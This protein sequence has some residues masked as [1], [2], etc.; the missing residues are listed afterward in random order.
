MRSIF[1]KLLL[2]MA[3]LCALPARAAL[4]V[5][6]CEP[7][8]GA[9]VHAL[10]GDLAKVYEATT[11]M[12]D[13]HHIQARP[14][15]IAAARRADLLVC[16]GAELEIGWLPVLTRDSGNAAIQ[17]GTPGYF[18][19]TR[20][21]TLIEVPA[22][23]DRSEGDVH[24]QGNPHIQTDPRNIAKVATA[25]AERLAAVDPPNAAEYRKRYADFAT[26]WQ[27]AIERWTREAAPLKGVRVVEHH[28]AFSYLFRWLGIEVTAYLEAKPG[29]EP[30]AGHLAE[31]LKLQQT[32]PAKFVVRASYIDPRAADWFSERARIPVVVLP[33]SVGGDAR[34]TD[35]FT[36]YDDLVG[37]L[38]KAGS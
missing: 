31:V 38:V 27:Q 26:R 13:V 15:L 23:L 16:T 1:T 20:Y 29:I 5:L 33:F 9:L 19:A 34:S 12:Q 30:S 32:R 7:E 11:A 14:S 2:V 35:L 25:L 37:S 24:P 3:L 4:N 18:E 17:P 8:W 28:R 21:V 22:R 10:A 36:W 6:V